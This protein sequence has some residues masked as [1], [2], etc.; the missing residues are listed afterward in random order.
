MK[1]KD[2]RIFLFFFLHKSLQSILSAFMH[3][4][5]TKSGSLIKHTQTD[6]HSYRCLAICSAGFGTCSGADLVE[7]AR[8]QMWLPPPPS[9]TSP[10]PLP[11]PPL[12]PSLNR[13]RAGMIDMGARSWPMKTRPAFFAYSGRAPLA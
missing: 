4:T 11:P 9:Y 2:S 3:A 10:T 8:G 12:A 6:T 13:S 1:T 7:M 5:L